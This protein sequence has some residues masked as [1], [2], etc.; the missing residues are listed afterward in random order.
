MIK[1]SI[2]S[3]SNKLV[4]HAKSLKIRKNRINNNQ[5]LI[6]GVRILKEAL[7]NN[8]IIEAVFCNDKLREVNGGH[9]LLEL[10]V[11]NHDVHMLSNK[12]F[13]TLSETENSQGIIAVIRKEDYLLDDVISKENLFFL[14]LDR[15]QDPGN[16]GTIIRTAKAVN[17]DAIILTK[18]C[19]DV[20]NSKAL[21]ATMGA[22]FGLPIIQFDNNDEWINKLEQ[23]NIKLIATSLKTERT[24]LD[25]SYNGS[26]AIVVGNEANGIDD[27]ILA[28]SDEVVK[29]QMFGKIESLN[30]TV[31]AAV[32]LYKAIEKRFY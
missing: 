14:V 6:E 19:V 20:Y 15:I 1:T 10:I 8:A 23:N 30:V 5:F 17:V 31:S 24:Y 25:I 16:I 18:G 4:K 29:I 2:D 27:K 22:L 28:K 3:E 12:V 21:R 13:S 32:L 9:E 26:I 11:K 7:D